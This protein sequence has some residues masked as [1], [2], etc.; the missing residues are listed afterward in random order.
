MPIN[1]PNNPSLNQLYDYDN[2]TWE[3]NGVY[4]EVYS[5][6]TSYVSTSTF[7]NY[8][9]VTQPLIYNSITGGTYSGGTLYL[10][11]NSG[12]TIQITGFTAGGLSGDYLPLSGGTV[13]GGTRFTSG[14]SA[15]TISATTYL[16]LPVDVFV[17]GGTYTSG[18]I[19]FR[20]ITGG[21]FTVTGIPSGNG[22]GGGIVYYLNLS[23]SQTPYREFSPIPT[24]AAQQSS[25][26]S[27]SNGS[28]ATISEFLTPVGYPNALILPGG[29][30][31][32]YLHS[33]KSNSN[34]IFQIF[35]EVYIRT[36][37]GTETFL[38]QTDSESVLSTSPAIEMQICDAYFS[39]TP[40]NVSDRLLVKVRATNTSNQTHTITL[41]TEGSQQYSY[42]T[43]T[44]SILGLTCDTLSGCSIIQTIQSDISNKYDK[45][46]G[47]INGNAFIDG[48][49]TANTISAT[50]YQNLPTD[51][52]VTGATYSDNTFTFINN[53]GST[54]DVSFNTVT[55]LTA[56]TISATTY[57]NLPTDIRVTGATYSDNTFT[58]IN[59]TGGTFDVS[60]NTVTGL[61]ANTISA[62]TYQNLPVSAVTSGSGISAV[63]SNGVV[64]VTNLSPDQTVTITGGTNIQIE[65]TYP[66]FGVNFTGTTGGGSFTG[67]TVSGATNF[68]GGLSAN[69]ISAT[70]ISGNTLFGDGANLTGIPRTGQITS[71]FDGLGGVVQTGI[72]RN[73]ITIPYTGTLTGWTIFSSVVGTID[74]D[75]YDDNYANFPPTSA[76]TIFTSINRPKLTNTNKNQATGLNIPLTSGDILIPEVLS[77]TG[78]T[79][80]VVNLQIIRTT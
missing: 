63:T 21:T 7:N 61:T 54:F 34:A 52:R 45:S 6:L 71:I 37:G 38:F 66:N 55:G 77:V 31:S 56:N 65:G 47:T 9:G 29:I 25:G 76:D 19:T 36:S 12:A 2:K 39:G 46:G 22:G 64:T 17:T 41:F 79:N 62:T 5:A 58:F 26:V 30:W 49:L 74:I 4:W 18:E 78:C 51:I 33:N 80:V 8:T 69:T 1:F 35:A 43:T 10:I 32:F 73:Y 13:S 40:L 28:T 44:F 11:N 60:F 72:G 67:G 27:I 42:A 20:N 3:W 57:Q 53:T 14:L 68:T 16:N 48:G 23:N 15:N 50:T 24:T 75:F 70:T 59:N